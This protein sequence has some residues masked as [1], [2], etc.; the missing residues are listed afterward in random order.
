MCAWADLN[1]GVDMLCPEQ[2]R[3]DASFTWQLQG[4]GDVSESAEALIRTEVN[5]C[6]GNPEEIEAA[7]GEVSQESSGFT[8]GGLQLY[9]KGMPTGRTCLLVSDYQLLV[10]TGH[11]HMLKSTCLMMY[12]LGA[13]GTSNV[14]PL[15]GWT[16]EMWAM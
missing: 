13:D 12:G 5:H 11:V 4:C 1:D 16:S 3:V 8:T 7:W 9:S 10:K 14:I 6:T 2:R 15:N